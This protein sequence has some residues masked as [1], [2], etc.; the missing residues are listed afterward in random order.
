MEQLA[1]TEQ[2]NPI[3]PEISPL[4]ENVGLDANSQEEE[5][6][7]SEMEKLYSETLKSFEEGEVVIGTVVQIGNGE[8]LV[9]VGYKSEGAIPLSEFPFSKDGKPAVEVGDKIEVYLEKKEDNDG[10]VVLSKEKAN[11]IKVWEAINRAHEEGIEITGRVMRKIKGGLT[12]DV[13]VPAF[14]PGSQ[15]DLRPVRDLDKLLGQHIR[16]KVIK[17]NAK[18]GNIVLSRRQLLEEERTAKKQE[19]LKELSEGKV[20]KGV[21]KNIT[22]YGAFVD[23]GG[24]DGLLHVT[25]MSWGRVRHPSE[26]FM[27]GD[28]VEVVVL[29]FDAA[30]ER[31][32]LGLKQKTS[33]PWENVEAKYQVSTRVRGKV[34]SLV[35]YGAFVELEEGVE[36]LIHISEMS[37]TRKVKHPNKILAMGDNVEV[38]VLGVDKGNKRI[39]LGLKQ[40]EPNP[41]DLVAQKYQVGS[42]VTGKVRNL[43]DF[44]AFVEL[45]EGI[46]GLIHIS[47]LSW[48]QRINHPSEIL[49][50]GDEIEAV[51]LSID[52]QNEKLSLGIKQLV[53]DP[54]LD[55][56]GK[57]PEGALIRRKVTKV[58]DFGAFVEIEVGIEGLI[59]VSELS[60][61]KVAPKDIVKEGDEL[62]MKVLKVD[63]EARKISLS[64]RA[65]LE[66]KTRDNVQ[67]YQNTE[68]LGNTVLSKDNKGNSTGENA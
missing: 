55:I 14:L 34:V 46:D 24:M 7:F 8:V 54:W 31:I 41:W 5:L 26:M 60:T 48:T 38:M 13:G 64:V 35:D 47:D 67:G 45:S 9:D 10:L 57:Y 27:L 51:V 59:H 37:W 62:D 61:K 33:D 56:P 50:K 4:G 1:T 49:K 53:N 28:E 23:L 11:K 12:V 68:Q 15:V 42:K 63:A 66:D 17:L 3:V 32:S 20:M 25:D 43:T 52:P 39:S 21:I 36:G 65:F 2:S 29:K 58:T 18:R 40:T 6:D 44:G 16:V 30:N 22:E 19:I